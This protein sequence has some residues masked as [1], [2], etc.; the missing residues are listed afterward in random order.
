MMRDI[1][2]ACNTIWSLL[3][4]T[5]LSPHSPRTLLGQVEPVLMQVVGDVLVPQPVH[6]QEVDDAF[7][8]TSAILRS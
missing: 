1:R 5:A 7:G 2:F 3:L 6:A 8:L 4:M